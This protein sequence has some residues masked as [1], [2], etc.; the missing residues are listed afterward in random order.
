PGI[1]TYQ[2]TGT[3][4][5]A[6]DVATVTVTEPVSPSAG[7]DN[8]LN[9]CAASAATNLFPLLTGAQAGGTWTAPGGGAFSGTYD[10]ATNASGVYTYTVNG[11]PPCAN[12][13][14]TVTVTESAAS[15]AGTNGTLAICSNAVATSLFTRLGG[16]P[17]A[18]GAWSGP[19]P[20]TAGQYD[21]AT[22]TPGVYTYTITGV[23]PCVNASA[24]VTVTENAPPNAGA[25]ASLP[26]CDQAAAVALISALPGADAGGTW[27]GPSPV[28]GGNY[29]PAT[30]TPGAYVYTV[31]GTAPCAND[32]ATVTVNETSTPNAGVNTSHALCANSAPV[33]LFTILTGEDAGGTW[34][35]PGGAVH[36]ST[37]DPSVDPAGVYTYTIAAV[38]PCAGDAATVT[39]TINAAPNAGADATLPVCDQAAAVALNS[40]L[41]GEDP[42]GTWSGPSP[43]VGGNYDPATMTPGAYVYTVTGTAPCANDQATVTVNETST[44]NAGT[45]TSHA[46]CANS[47]PVDLFTILTGEDAGG[48]WTAPGG[49]AHTSTIDPSVDP[50]GVYT[51]TI[52]AVPPCA[53]DAAT[54]TITI[55]AAP[56]AG[57]DATLPVCDQA[58]AVALNSA[59]TGE[60]AGGTW[61][62]PSPVVGGNY[63]PAT[64]TPG[65]YV[66]TVTGTAP[67]ANDQATVTVN[68]TST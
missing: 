37:I 46:L 38:P 31:T 53:G 11:T 33:D 24:T 55:N 9:I 7:A 28:V 26:V 44:P 42:G 68:E 2:V 14:A 61:S 43:V 16:T 13:Q 59:L 18:G 10:P 66:Y 29:D 57:A 36:A 27:S 40:A 51:Y 56:N 6:A 15:D 8:S 20:V 63:D 23:A 50:A 62:G 41:T 45:N 22:M 60:D 1:Y 12:D 3:A 67:C 64:M 21:P 54:V 34:T 47:A 5:C 58:A 19:S 65:A 32:Q 48:T 52:A 4:P 25:D 49:A 30:M 39:I 17:Q 35:A